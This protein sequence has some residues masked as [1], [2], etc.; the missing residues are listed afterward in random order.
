MSHC[1]C[2]RLQL[3]LALL[4]GMD[5]RSAHQHTR[6]QCVE[7]QHWKLDSASVLVITRSGVH[8]Y[9]GSHGGRKLP[10][11]E[12]WLKKGSIRMAP[13]YMQSHVL[14]RSFDHTFRSWCSRCL[15]L[16]GTPSIVSCLDCL[17]SPHRRQQPQRHQ[18]AVADVYSFSAQLSCLR[19]AQLRYVCEAVQ[20]EG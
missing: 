5:S 9:R 18:P 8:L 17:L 4:V 20:A 10:H 6:L 7:R 16:A 12:L 15:Q 14:I 1:Q 19:L 3:Q 13:S 2:L 11:S